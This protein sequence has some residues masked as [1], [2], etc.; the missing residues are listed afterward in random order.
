M[1]EKDKGRYADSNWRFETFVLANGISWLNTPFYNWRSNNQKN[2]TTKNDNP[3]EYFNR[4]NEIEEFL[5]NHIR[6]YE[7]IKDW[8]YKLKYHMYFY[9]LYRL[10]P[11]YKKQCLRRIYNEFKEMDYNIVV[12]SRI[13]NAYDKKLFKD[14]RD[15]S[16]EKFIRYYYPLCLIKGKAKKILLKIKKI[17]VRFFAEKIFPQVKTDKTLK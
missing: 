7:Q 15:F 17:E 2:S 4:F 6:K 10:L 3:D 14:A 11:G 9:N 16:E 12:N 5:N 8:F 13:F 1:Q